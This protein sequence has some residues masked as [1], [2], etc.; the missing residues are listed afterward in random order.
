MEYTI[1]EKKENVLLSRTELSIEIEHHGSPNPSASA[2]KKEIAKQ[3]NINENLIVIR[4]IYPAFGEGK[5][6]VIAY[7]YK[8]ESSLKS[9]EP[10]NK[11]AEEAAKKS[12][13]EAKKSAETKPDTQE[14]ATPEEN[15]EA[16]KEEKKETKP[17]GEK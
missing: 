15:K 11:K 3:L 12:A 10:R 14:Q 9:I 17:E 2:V 16:P 6:E 13:E 1:K 8:D 7:A 5:S 4:H